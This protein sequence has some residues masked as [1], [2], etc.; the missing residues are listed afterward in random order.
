MWPLSQVDLFWTVLLSAI[1]ARIAIIDQRKM[2]IPDHLNILLASVGLWR[3]AEIGSAA[4]AWAL[5]S[6]TIG[7]ASLLCLRGLYWRARRLHALGMG[8]VKFA[9]AAATWIGIAGLPWLMLLAAVSGLL[10]A[11]WHA[12]ACGYIDRRA[13]LPFGPHL[14]L[15]LLMVHAVTPHSGNGFVTHVLLH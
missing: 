12:R 15:A 1:L 2:I 4:M 8:D 9:G 11:L 13:K 7:G 10:A 6:G 3:A 14:A 5:L